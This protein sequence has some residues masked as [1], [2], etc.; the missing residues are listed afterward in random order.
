[1]YNDEFYTI[2]VMI[3]IILSENHKSND[4]S[5]G[6]YDFCAIAALLILG[7][8]HKCDLIS[9]VNYLMLWCSHLCK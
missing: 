6:G 1:M 3:M 2:I 5:K 7:E 4:N 9:L 8:T